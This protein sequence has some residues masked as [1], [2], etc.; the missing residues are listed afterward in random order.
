VSATVLRRTSLNRYVL[1]ADIRVRN[2]VVQ[3]LVTWRPSKHVGELFSRLL[4]ATE[5][6]AS[7]VAACPL[8]AV[9]ATAP[10]SKTCI[11]CGQATAVG[12]SPPSSSST[13]VL[14]WLH[15]E[16]IA[17][18]T[19]T[20]QAP[21]TTTSVTQLKH[22]MAELPNWVIESPPIPPPPHATDPSCP[23]LADLPTETL[24]HI[25]HFCTDVSA[26][27]CTC[28]RLAAIA[29]E[30]I[31]ELNL[32][33]HPHQRAG[34]R[35]ML[36]RE[37]TP[38]KLPH[39]F[40]RPLPLH[41]I[42]GLHAHADCS[43]GALSMDSPASISDIA[44]GFYCD[45]PGLGKTVTSLALILKTTGLCPEAP[46]GA[47]VRGGAVSV[48]TSGVRRNI[49]GFEY[50]QPASAAGKDLSEFVAAGKEAGSEKNARPLE[51]P[52]SLSSRVKR[53][54]AAAA[55]AAA[56]PPMATSSQPL[57]AD[58]EQKLLEEVLQGSWQ[59][60]ASSSGPG[61]VITSGSP[62]AS[63]H[64][65][66]V[67]PAGRSWPLADTASTSCPQTFLPSV[68]IS[69]SDTA[70]SPGL[71]APLSH[72]P[73]CT[74]PRHM[75]MQQVINHNAP[76]TSPSPSMP[77]TIPLSSATLVVVPNTL[78]KHW[79]EQ[80]GRHTKPGVLRVYAI[81]DRSTASI[82][83]RALAW[84]FD[85]V[86]TTFS[87]LSSLGGPPVTASS[88][89]SMSAAAA[90][91]AAASG[92]SRA[93]SNHV[94]LHI[95]WLRVILDEGH[96]LGTVNITNRLRVICALRAERRWVLTGTP[97]PSSPGSP[98]S[99]LQ[100][101]L[102]FLGNQPYG[103]SAPQFEAAIKVPFEASRPLGVIC[104]LHGHVVAASFD[105]ETQGSLLHVTVSLLTLS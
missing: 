33:L 78:V 91:A 102:A 63:R 14:P 41:P 4:P 72:D 18:D 34:L 21:G 44:G 39:P 29:E 86:L 11:A 94:L 79:A 48:I 90:A 74:G 100:P 104:M 65:R 52:G 87:L 46:R 45:E 23:C 28:R 82:E 97:T 59:L 60:T 70:A 92:H 26:V 42:E 103:C 93:A 66:N 99:A 5:V 81:L 80:I 105:S 2:E 17:A 10:S 53:R 76:P 24:Q 68:S 77:S 58:E 75:V 27:A 43:T 22:C 98:V 69:A 84:D 73:V 6:T 31:P 20:P 19:L 38:K 12:T 49:M 55:A 54:R 61:N 51:G 7:D 85:I 50:F 13:S 3:G 83:P 36:D 37:R 57:S 9:A 16:C 96:L 15:P 89:K 101:L 8:C 47:V 32:S 1:R 30:V 67:P 62:T 64:L 56:A 25:L 40:I 95:H 35:R 71:F 88:G